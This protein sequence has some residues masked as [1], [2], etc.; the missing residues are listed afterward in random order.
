[1]INAEA[2]SDTRDFL[3]V[4]GATKA[5]TT[6]L[7]GFLDQHPAIA[8][9]RVKETNHFC[10]DLWPLMPHIPI[11]GRAGIAG[12][13]AKPHSF[14]AGIVKDP[15][16]YLTLFPR[17]T[18]E[19]YLGEASPFYLRSTAAPGALFAR[20]PTARLI[21]V[22]RDP[23]DRAR[24]HHRMEVRNGRLP[25]S[26]SVAV[27]EELGLSAAGQ[28]PRHG[29]I[30]SGCYGLAL[31]RYRSV[32][33]ASQMLLLD[34]SELKNPKALGQRLAEFLD[35]DPLGFGDHLE[36][37]NQWG[38]ARHDR[39]NRMLAQFGL[40]FAIRQL[41]PQPLIEALKP[42][43]YGKPKPSEPLDPELEA[44][45]RRLYREDLKQ[46]ALLTDPSRF[47]WISRYLSMA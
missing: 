17:P 25:S 30:E 21:L 19:R 39:L 20:F 9:S 1:M 41:L 10:Q 46:L 34:L 28:R 12:I 42:L 23:I 14:H 32:F 3:A 47:P 45:L 15:A 4:I 43:Y 44:R 11:L 2:E 5:G 22:L 26:F 6:A 13:M 16:D 7:H 27:A 35:I 8:M 36:A 37:A 38:D 29:L 24:S 18:T 31:Q 40:K 33:P